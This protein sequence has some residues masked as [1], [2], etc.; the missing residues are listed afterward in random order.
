[1]KIHHPLFECFVLAVALLIASS[2]QA[3][4]LFV[5]ERYGYHL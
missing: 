3:Q 1:M 2:A 5:T 4:N